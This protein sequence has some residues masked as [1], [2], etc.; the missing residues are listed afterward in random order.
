[1]QQLSAD[2]T[3][4]VPAQQDR[5]RTGRAAHRPLPERPDHDD[6]AAG[7]AAPSRVWALLEAMAY[8]GAIIDPTGVLAAERFR[9][10]IGTA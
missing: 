5:E 9:R 8:A 1:M 2:T 3:P 4:R 7:R 6:R 10:R